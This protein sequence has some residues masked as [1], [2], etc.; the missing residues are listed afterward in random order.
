MTDIDTFDGAV[1]QLVELVH[2]PNH[3]VPKLKIRKVN[4]R[5]RISGGIQLDLHEDHRRGAEDRLAAAHFQAVDMAEVNRLQQS[6]KNLP[7][8]GEV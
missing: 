8:R 3:F 5:T 7:K 2:Q 4:F 6:H 1:A